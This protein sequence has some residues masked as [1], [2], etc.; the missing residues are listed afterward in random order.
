MNENMLISSHFLSK[1]SQRSSFLGAGEPTE[2]TFWF[3]KAR[4]HG[5]GASSRAAYDAAP[6]LLCLDK[7]KSQIYI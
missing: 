4:Q 6:D 5:K 2:E 3:S 7:S 1:Q